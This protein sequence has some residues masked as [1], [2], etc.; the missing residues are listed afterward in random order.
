MEGCEVVIPGDQGCC[1]ALMEH[2]G[3]EESALAYARGMIATMQDADVDIV[4]INA[5]GCGSTLKEYGHLLRDDP[6]WAERAAAFAAKVRDISELL[7]ELEPRATRHPIPARVAYHDACHLAHAQGIRRQPRAVLRTIPELEVVELSEPD[8]CCGSAGIYNLLQPDAAADLGVRK[9]ATVAAVAP[10]AVVTANPG[11][12]LQI[13]RHLD[14][15]IPLLHPVQL[16][17]ASLRGGDPLAGY[18]RASRS[19]ERPVIPAAGQP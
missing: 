7:D 17:D 6:V 2:A 4:A 1:G 3:E 14:A 15:D 5:A 13:K 19:A 8:I 12:M 18:R 11:C 10:D 9:A 16:V